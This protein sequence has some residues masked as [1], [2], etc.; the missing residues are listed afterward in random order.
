MLV[1]IHM[2]ITA[3]TIYLHSPHLQLFCP[4]SDGEP[5]GLQLLDD[6]DAHLEFTLPANMSRKDEDTPVAGLCRAT[7]FFWLP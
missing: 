6:T 5:H 3:R 1:V 2:S 7:F 4:L